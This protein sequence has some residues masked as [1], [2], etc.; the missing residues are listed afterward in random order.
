MKLGEDTVFFIF[1]LIL[2][3]SFLMFTNVICIIVSILTK[4]WRGDS[5]YMGL[6]WLF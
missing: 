2:N 6:P 1:I 3:E 5:S 4:G